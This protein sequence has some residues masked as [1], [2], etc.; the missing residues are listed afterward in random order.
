M[1]V[2]WGLTVVEVLGGLTMM[3]GKFVKPIALIFAVH[4]TTGIYLLHLPKG[5]FVSGAGRNGMEFRALLI[6]A[7]IAVALS[8]PKWS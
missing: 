5:W 7:Y 3:S 1:I 2:A 6:T 8:R 4:L